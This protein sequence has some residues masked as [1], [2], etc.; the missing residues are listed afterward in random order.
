MVSYILLICLP[1]SS[2]LVT[3]FSKYPTVPRPH[4]ALLSQERL[5]VCWI[6]ES[7]FVGGCPYLLRSKTFRQLVAKGGT[8]GR[9]AVACC[10]FT[11]IIWIA[12][13]LAD[14]LKA[15]LLLPLPRLLGQRLHWHVQV[16]KAAGWGQRECWDWNVTRRYQQTQSCWIMTVVFHDP[17]ILWHSSSV[18]CVI[19]TMIQSTFSRSYCSILTAG[20]VPDHHPNSDFYK[21][22]RNCC[23]SCGNTCVLE[24]TEFC[25]I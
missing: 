9:S 12:A 17:E 18:H 3:V 6:A 25:I 5:Y 23:W 4:T 10:V 1:V 13:M 15:S 11:A 24:H 21:T 8:L 19:R 20:R 22:C 16:W 7:P 2:L 14:F